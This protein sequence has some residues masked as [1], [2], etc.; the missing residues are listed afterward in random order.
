MDGHAMAICK[1]KDNMRLQITKRSQM[2]RD[3][4]LPADEKVCTRQDGRKWGI[5]AHGDNVSIEEAITI[6]I[7]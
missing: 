1:T 3:A 6:Y 5:C 7:L 4:T 2:P